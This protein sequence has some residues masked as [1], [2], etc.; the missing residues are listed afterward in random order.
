MQEQFS[1]QKFPIRD[2][3]DIEFYGAFCGLWTVADLLFLKSNV[4]PKCFAVSAG[5]IVEIT[6]T[7]ILFT[8]P[9]LLSPGQRK[10]RN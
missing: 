10:T 4:L 3:L 1:I 5:V 7:Y 9:L 6:I 8:G 2:V